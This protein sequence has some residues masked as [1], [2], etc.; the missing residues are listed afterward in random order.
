MIDFYCTSY[1]FS[2]RSISIE[3]SSGNDYFEDDITLDEVDRLL[4]NLT[5]FKYKLFKL[6]EKLESEN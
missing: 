2:P 4:N 6:R 1:K 5:E 3:V